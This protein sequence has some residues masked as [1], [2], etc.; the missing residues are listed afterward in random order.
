M[1]NAGLKCAS[2]SATIV[3]ADL[4]QATNEIAKA[5]QYSIL[6]EGVGSMFSF[7]VLRVNIA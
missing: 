4:R 6:A 1:M 2:I 3:F 5:R 7:A